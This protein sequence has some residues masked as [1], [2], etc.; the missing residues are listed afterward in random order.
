MGADLQVLWEVVE[1]NDLQQQLLSSDNAGRKVQGQEEILEDCELQEE[2][3]TFIHPIANV[4]TFA[5]TR[6]QKRV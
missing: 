5:P 6:S 4:L 2:H 3:V 1:E